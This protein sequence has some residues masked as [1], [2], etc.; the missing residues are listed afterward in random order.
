MKTLSAELIA[1]IA[2]GIALAGLQVVGQHRLEDR[3]LAVEKE[4][5]RVGV[6]LGRVETEQARVGVILERVEKEQVR[7][8]AILEGVETEQAR[9]RVLH[10]GVGFTAH[11]HDTT[12][13]RE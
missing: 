3:L 12:P 1:I 6:V 8:G 7:V 10:E 4:Q 11:T 5:A 13:D 9:F 2:T